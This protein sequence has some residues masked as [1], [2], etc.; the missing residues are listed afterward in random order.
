MYA[1]GAPD[2]GATIKEALSMTSAAGTGMGDDVSND[3]N[4]TPYQI[5]SELLVS[6]GTDPI[7]SVLTVGDR[8][9]QQTD[10]IRG[11]S[12]L[13]ENGFYPSPPDP[14]D[15]LPSIPYNEMRQ[16]QYE[17][18]HHHLFI[19]KSTSENAMHSQIQ[20]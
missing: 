19:D 1:S 11:G 10:N 7:D 16:Q 9:S 18:L 2:L 4:Q 17:Q 12:R 5:P 14:D 15:M 6:S 8:S 20:R 13:D 3:I